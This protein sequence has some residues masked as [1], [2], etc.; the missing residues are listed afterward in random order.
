M[1]GGLLHCML[2]WK[3][4]PVML[5]GHDKE[6]EGRSLEQRKTTAQDFGLPQLCYKNVSLRK[7][8]GKTQRTQKIH[9]LEPQEFLFREFIPKK[10][11]ISA[12]A[13]ILKH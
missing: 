10:S 13:L 8:N 5:R 11:F 2:K 6:H 3:L 1:P 12:S 4:C 9:I 7:E